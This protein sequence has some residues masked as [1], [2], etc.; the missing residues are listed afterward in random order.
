ML[1]PQRRWG[2]LWVSRETVAHLPSRHRQLPSGAVPGRSASLGRLL[3]EARLLV[4]LIEHDA[5]L[6]SGQLTGLAH[7]DTSLALGLERELAPA[8]L[9]HLSYAPDADLLQVEHLRE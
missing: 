6:P 7:D 9:F 4:K 8:S 5:E 2:E 3:S 1:S